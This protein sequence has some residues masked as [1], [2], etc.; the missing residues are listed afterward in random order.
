MP[1]YQGAGWA[2]IA[3]L[4]ISACSAPQIAP[5]SLKDPIV[6]TAI[7][8]SGQRKSAPKSEPTPVA[9]SDA[10]AKSDGDK[11]ARPVTISPVIV[12][13]APRLISQPIALAMFHALTA[14]GFEVRDGGEWKII[15]TIVGTS[16]SWEI[17]DPDGKSVGKIDQSG[18]SAASTEAIIAGLKT[19][20]PRP[21]TQL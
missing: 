10:G 11:A 8:T 7:S 21:S 6:Q 14:A 9:K 5:A 4:A 15:G 12:N 16:V 3:A 2:L 19:Y 18:M 13:G 1:R 17:S 20:L